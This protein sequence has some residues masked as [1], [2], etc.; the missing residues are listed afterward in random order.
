MQ[1][2]TSEALQLVRDY[3]PWFLKKVGQVK[4]RRVPLTLSLDN[5]DDNPLLLYACLWYADSGQVAIRFVP[6]RTNVS[7]EPLVTK[8]N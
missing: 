8:E 5:F 6:K 2:I 3:A 1:P 7:P 4:R